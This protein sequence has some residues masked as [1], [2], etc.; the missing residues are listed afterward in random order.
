M[1]RSFPHHA[2]EAGP[3]I[4]HAICRDCGRSEDFKATRGFRLK[5]LACPRCGGPFVGTTSGRHF[6]PCVVCGRRRLVRK[7]GFA[8]CWFHSADTVY[9]ARRRLAEQ[10]GQVVDGGQ[11]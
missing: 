9:A 3:T 2:H 5:R 8:R 10:R 1:S 7:D 6:G 11:S 4:I